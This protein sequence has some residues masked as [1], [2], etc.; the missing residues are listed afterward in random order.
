MNKIISMATAIVLGSTPAW[1]ESW[2]LSN[3]YPATSLT[4]IVAEKFAELVGEETNGDVQITVHHGGAL[5]Y[6]STDHFDAVSDGSLQIALSPYAFW[7]GIDP[8]FQLVSLPFVAPTTD[9]AH[10]LLEIARPEYEAVLEG[11]NQ[12]MLVG[13]PYPSS[14]LWGNNDFT[15]LEDLKNAKVRTY[16]V[17]STETLRNAGALPLQ[18]SWADVPAQLSTN[19]IEAV[20]TSPNAGVG[21]QMWE[22]QSH[23]TAVNFGAAL[24]AIHVNR[25]VFDELSEDHQK[26][27]LKAAAEAEAYGW[28]LATDLTQNDF[29]KM[30]DNGMTI[31]EELSPEYVEQLKQ[32]GQPFIESWIDEVGD[33]A[34]NVLSEYNSQ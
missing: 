22:L 6:K 24:F 14:G 20:L 18:I 16:D 31:V 5:G 26:G 25:D 10:R 11:A 12:L 15:S 29:V 1:A 17:A 19:A 28:E 34:K 8:I 21:V 33:R 32:A 9:D 13:A 7:T 27:V 3:E 4:G 30:R 2:D 23:F